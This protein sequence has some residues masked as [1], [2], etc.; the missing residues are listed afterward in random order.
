MLQRNHV[1]SK[2]R[3]V[4]GAILNRSTQG[5]EVPNRRAIRERGA[6]SQGGDCRRRDEGEGRAERSEDTTVLA[7]AVARAEVGIMTQL[8][9]RVADAGW[10]AGTLIHDAIIVEKDGQAREFRRLSAEVEDALAAAA[11]E[12]GWRRGLLRAKVTET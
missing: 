6:Q 2:H 11:E 12:R 4:E 7:H 5:E 3:T 1:R 10:H 9:K 8:R